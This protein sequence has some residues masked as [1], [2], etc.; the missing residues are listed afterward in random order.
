MMD[1]EEQQVMAMMHVQVIEDRINPRLLGGNARIDPGEKVDEMRFRA[2]RVTLRP[3]I[4][5]RFPQR[6]KDI[7]LGASAIIDLLFSALGGPRLDSNG[8]LAG[9]A[10]GGHRPHLVD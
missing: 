3:A 4:S 1:L 2:A 5:G 6:A 9:I 7:A 10:L 8:V